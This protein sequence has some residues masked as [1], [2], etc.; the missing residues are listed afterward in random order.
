MQ[1]D[2][3]IVGA[4]HSLVVHSSLLRGYGYSVAT[5]TTISETYILLAQGMRPQT[6]II[7]LKFA[8]LLEF[9]PAMRAIG[10]KGV[11]IIVIGAESAARSLML[12]QGANMVLRKP[13]QP[14]DVLEAVQYRRKVS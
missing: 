2:I 1:P 14:E 3:L 10:G 12:K 13:V 6:V 5:T 7:D 11:K 8:D 9:I 4:H